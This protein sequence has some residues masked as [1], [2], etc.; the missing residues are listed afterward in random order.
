[1]AKIVLGKRP[2]SFKKTITFPTPDGTEGM[3]EVTYK[4]R[5]TTEY[6]TFQD[7]WLAARKAKIEAEAA[8]EAEKKK[9][10]D[11]AGEAY[12]AP[13]MTNEELRRIEVDANTDYL[14]EI[15]SGWNLDIGFDR[16]SVFQLCDEF[17]GAAR[18]IM[19]RYRAAITEGRLGN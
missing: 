18:E 2:E 7:A 15:I 6:G 16:D 4:Y 9:K 11:A 3:M 19:D 12:T 17:P 1:M 5:T 13:E 8:Q 14:L 10:A